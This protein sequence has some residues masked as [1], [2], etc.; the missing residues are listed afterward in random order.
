LLI[1]VK[2]TLGPHTHTALER[3]TYSTKSFLT[4]FTLVSGHLTAD[5]AARVALVEVQSQIDLWGEVEDCELVVSWWG[6]GSWWWWWC[7]CWWFVVKWR[8]E[9]RTPFLPLFRCEEEGDAGGAGQ[10]G[11]PGRPTGN[12]GNSSM[13]ELILSGVT[14]SLASPLT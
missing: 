11:S 2:P 5:E 10:G 6:R 13:H 1:L 12:V 4:A 14:L 8:G 3:A 7:W 9:E